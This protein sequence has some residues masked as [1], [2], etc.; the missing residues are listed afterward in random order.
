M[1]HDVKAALIFAE[2]TATWE[3]AAY[4]EKLEC[5]QKQW[6]DIVSGVKLYLSRYANIVPAD[7][8]VNVCR[9]FM[10]WRRNICSKP[11]HRVSIENVVANIVTTKDEEE[12]GRR[13]EGRRRRQEEEEG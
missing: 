5:S 2:K 7:A 1:Q 12:G 3:S 11:H 6:N 9:K 4:W 8:P 13:R 10:E